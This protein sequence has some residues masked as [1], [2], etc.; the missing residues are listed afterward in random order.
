MLQ[1]FEVGPPTRCTCRPCLTRA[2]RAGVPSLR[3]TV[4]AWRKSY[5]IDAT[6]EGTKARLTSILVRRRALDGEQD[7]EWQSED[8]LAAGEK[9]SR[10]WR[11]PRQALTLPQQPAA[12]PACSSRDRTDAAR[13][14][15]GMEQK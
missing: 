1:I 7:E 8:K 2:D 4:V 11:L 15:S 10:A 12:R 13:I 3:A 14:S 9:V 5:R 6:K